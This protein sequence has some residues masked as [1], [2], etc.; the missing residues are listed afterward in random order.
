[1]GEAERR[2]GTRWVRT[3]K[4]VW[5]AMRAR[6]SWLLVRQERTRRDDARDSRKMV[7]SW[8]PGP[9]K[10]SGWSDSN[11]QPTNCV[12]KH[13]GVE[14]GLSD[15]R[16]VLCTVQRYT[17]KSLP[18]RTQKSESVSKGNFFH[19][20][21]ESHPCSCPS[22]A[23]LT[24][25]AAHAPGPSRVRHKLR[26]PGARAST[27]RST[28]R[29]RAVTSEIQIPSQRASPGEQFPIARSDFARRQRTRTRRWLS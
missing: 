18:S 14:V 7:M 29:A 21:N 11:L 4:C 1:V 5:A 6:A 3:A 23:G 15:A 16:R 13:S 22:A 8:S 17:G 12:D 20:K 19:V 9:V 28:V 24:S 27:S 25:Y 10:W 26:T 2:A